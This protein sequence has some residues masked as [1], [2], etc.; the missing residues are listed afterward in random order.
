MTVLELLAGTFLF[1]VLVTLLGQA[2]PCA[3]PPGQISE[4]TKK[5]RPRAHASCRRQRLSS[6]HEPV[7]RHPPRLRHG[8]PALGAEA[9]L[10]PPEPSAN[11]LRRRSDR[12]AA[13]K[14]VLPGVGKLSATPSPP[15]AATGMGLTRSP[16][17]STR[18]APSWGI[19]LGLPVN[20][21]SMTLSSYEDGQ[22]AGLGILRGKCVRFDVDTAQNLKVPHM[23]WNQLLI[24]RP[25]PLFAGLP[26]DASVYVVHS[27]HVV[28]DDESIIATTTEYGRPFVS[29][30]RRD[31][32]MAT[33]FHPEKSQ[34]VGLAILANFARI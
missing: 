32:L 9:P 16:A 11:R 17:T 33:Q 4:L 13:E 22:H 24:R 29:S 14:I 19:C 34:K 5:L 21:F 20:A 6:S 8:Q 7:H 26:G 18:A 25:S 15:S 2:Q 12:Q 3:P 1:G 10:A 27:Y 31:N 30:I 23:G 28:P